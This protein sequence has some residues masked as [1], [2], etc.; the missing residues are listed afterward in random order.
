MPGCS[1]GEEVYSLA[2]LLL[3][4]LGDKT[5]NVPI[6]IYATDISERSLEK[7]RL[8]VYPE[9]IAADVSPAR[10]RRYFFKLQ[11]S[12]QISK[13]VRELC[14]FARQNIAKDPP[15][16]N[17]DLISCRN[18]LIYL[19]PLLQKRVMPV[20]HYALRADRFLLLGG[21]ETTSGSESLFAPLD[22]KHRIYVKR[23]TATR[24]T[25]DFSLQ[26]RA[27]GER[28]PP[29][30]PATDLRGV[31]VQREAD[32]LLLGRFAP[33]SVLVNEAMEILQF[34][35]H[36][37]LYLEP[38]SG[39]ASLDVLKMA[40]EGLHMEL[41]TALH[42]ARRQGVSVRRDGLRVKHNGG[43]NTVNFEV[44]PIRSAGSR[45]RH[46][47]V[48]FEEA[49]QHAPAGMGVA[50]SHPPKAEKL[51]NMTVR[52]EQ[53]LTA[54]KEYMQSVVE[55]LQDA[56]EE[57]K[58]A[59]EEIQSSNEELQSTNEELETAK[60][61]LQSTNEELTTVN[62]EQQNRNIETGRLNSDLTNLLTSVDVPI[63]MLD[64][65]LR[66]RQMTPAAEQVL[67]L[68]HADIGRKV[69]DLRLT[70]DV[71]D[72]DR[73]V[74]DSIDSLHVKARD[75]QDR[76]GHW[77]SL[78]VRPYR[79]IENKIEG[80]V[81]T[82]LDID[83]IKRSLTMAEQ[84]TQY[85]EAIIETVRKPLLVLNS[86]LR[87]RSANVAYYKMFQ[88][89]KATTEGRYI[90]DLGNGQWNIPRLRVLLKDILPKQ[91]IFEDFEVTHEF[92]KIGR[93]T[94][95][96]NARQLRFQG[97]GRN[98]ILMAMEDITER[99]QLQ[100]TVLDIS[101]QEREQI[102]LNIHEG[103]AQYL[104]GIAFMAG[105]LHDRL[106]KKSSNEV[107]DVDELIKLLHKACEV[108]ND[109]AKGLFPVQL[110]REGLTRAL[111][112]LVQ[113]TEDTFKVR[114]Q[115]ISDGAVRIGDVNVVR[116]FYRIAQEAVNNAIRHGK[117]KHIRI[118][119]DQKDGLITL[120]VTDDGKDSSK[121]AVKPS[122][123]GL[124][125]MNY[126]ARAMGGTLNVQ[127]VRGKG[128]TVICTVP[129]SRGS[130]HEAIEESLQENPS[131][132]RK[133]RR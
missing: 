1:T 126:R 32:R 101:E 82:L 107:A 34:R 119:L 81:I 84:A 87:I 33:A 26:E 132:K 93:R 115:F 69:T 99:L 120:T 131:K 133:S 122:A 72:L 13:S 29:Y 27:M 70:V 39:T 28:E 64:A 80:A 38:A 109:M 37:G 52:L 125:I 116:Q 55:E 31:D 24:P 114:C 4:Y 100:R 8:G 90:Y 77:Y 117:G 112:A 61:E 74:T 44:V 62:E 40:R 97:I 6:Q 83:A 106:R 124:H 11:G 95:L 68:V 130:G 51:E 7:A 89:T 123:M 76:D 118:H 20:F 79:T 92:P 102:G 36:T 71:P 73:L 50:E 121:S 54:T 66:V 67:H 46:F 42:K 9:S 30:N 47:L 45:E 10:L 48:L 59:N 128:T 17:L 2:I 60:E 14:V 94:M 104:T 3:E 110:I 127:S 23:M 12:Y 41:R 91:S 98:M 108:T 65:D 96:L 78:R 19:S 22:R 75:V 103:L 58:A 49:D 85:A 56:N 15:F 18:V 25:V 113:T 35:G 57:L 63:L 129:H 5:P 53:E 21:A 86:D 105:A 88:E 111:E 16:S 43:F